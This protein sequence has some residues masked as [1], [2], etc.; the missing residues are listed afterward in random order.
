M[1]SAR[2]GV[3]VIAT[4]LATPGTVERFSALPH[5]TAITSSTT[6]GR[7]A[8]GMVLTIDLRLASP[9][10]SRIAIRCPAGLHPGSVPRGEHRRR[11]HTGSL[12][13]SV[14]LELEQ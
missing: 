13:N 1:R 14:V 5:A 10:R 11:R 6:A 3:A 12:V 4:G 2:A 9:L 7:S 8:I